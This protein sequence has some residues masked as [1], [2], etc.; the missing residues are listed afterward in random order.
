M[1][2]ITEQTPEKQGVTP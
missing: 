2:K 1:I